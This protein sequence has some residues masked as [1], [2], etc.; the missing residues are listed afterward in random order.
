M[1]TLDLSFET[2]GCEW[3]FHLSVLTFL[4][5]MHPDEPYFIIIYY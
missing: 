3:T 2:L 1:K 5:A 4:I